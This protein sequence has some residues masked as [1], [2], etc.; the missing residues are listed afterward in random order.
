[1]AAAQVK[2]TWLIVG[3]EGQLGRSLQ[4]ALKIRDISF[5]T[6]T[7]RELDIT[8]L[9]Q[10]KDCLKKSSSEVIVN[11]AA[12]T[13]VEQAELEATNAF[14]VNE[15]GARNLAIAARNLDLK[16]V[17]FSTDYV[18]SGPKSQPWRVTDEV[19]PLSVY[20]KSKLAGEIAIMEEYSKN[21]LVVR[22]AWLY[23]P[24]GK[25]FY[26]SILNLALN[27]SNQINVVNDQFGQPTNAQDLSNLVISALSNEVPSGIYHGSNTGVATWYDFAIEIFKLVGA[28]TNRINSISSKE[29]KTQ[30]SRPEYSVLDNSKW[31]EF[32]VKTLDPWKES[33]IRAFPAIYESLS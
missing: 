23:S 33:V 16:L 5:Q 32:G 18:F 20:G 28:D 30:A 9:P 7:R 25:N 22:T 26:K 14:S 10:V 31:S 15:K 6:L 1:V 21:S 13:N 4:E 12:Y 17:H 2:M 29:Y 3:A 8:D 27:S 11:A 24:Y 19:K